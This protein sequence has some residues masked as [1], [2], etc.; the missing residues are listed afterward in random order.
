MVA[1]KI[2]ISRLYAGTP[3]NRISVMMPLTAPLLGVYFFG[4]ISP[5][6]IG[7]I[8]PFLDRIQ[9]LS[10]A[11]FFLLVKKKRRLLCMGRTSTAYKPFAL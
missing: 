1:P 3:I 7:H 2:E 9:A 8:A 11:R 6:K 5:S 10:K 4:G